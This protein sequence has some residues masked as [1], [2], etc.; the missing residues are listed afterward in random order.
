MMSR[1]EFIRGT[2]AETKSAE[3][4]TSRLYTRSIAHIPAAGTA[5]ERTETAASAS[6]TTTS[7]MSGANA[8]LPQ[9]AKVNA[10]THQRFSASSTVNN[11]PHKSYKKTP[12]RKVTD[13]S[14]F[15]RL[16]QDGGALQRIGPLGL[17]HE[18]LHR[19]GN[20]CHVI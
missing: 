2:K 16:L 12:R 8:V 1:D 6:R 9:H 19:I 15:G 18:P 10:F 20:I 7:M 13:A 17:H 5:A 11:S 14:G 3:D 4:T